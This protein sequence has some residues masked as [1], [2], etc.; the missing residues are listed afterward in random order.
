MPVPGAAGVRAA[1]I[2]VV[3]MTVGFGGVQRVVQLDGAGQIEVDEALLAEADQPVAGVGD[4]DGGG[5]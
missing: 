2:A 4:L 1:R 3:A 5:G